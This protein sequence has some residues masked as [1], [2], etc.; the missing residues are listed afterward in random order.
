MTISAS[1]GRGVAQFV[2]VI[3]W[4]TVI[5]VWRVL[6]VCYVSNSANGLGRNK[7]C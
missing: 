7:L 4:T 5:D 2:A 3:C 6:T 1:G